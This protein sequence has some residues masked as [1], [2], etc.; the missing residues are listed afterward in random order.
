MA[1]GRHFIIANKN[2]VCMQEP[3]ENETELY[4]V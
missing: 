1:Y 4:A 2:H 3:M